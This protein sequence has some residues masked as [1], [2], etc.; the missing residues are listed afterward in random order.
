MERVEYSR[1]QISDLFRKAEECGME[2][3]HLPIPNGGVPIDPEADYYE[4]FIED[5]VKR[6]EKGQTVVAHC[7]GGF[8]RSG[9]V[10]ASVLV[11]LGHPAGKAIEI[12][13]EARE[14]AV[15]TPDQE[16]RIYWFEMEIQAE[17][18]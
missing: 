1:F 6:L 12:V 7:R 2:V 9:L 18:N 5:I 16:E 13:R 4:A 10:A 11:A 17:G 15:E 14:G 3:F 8:G